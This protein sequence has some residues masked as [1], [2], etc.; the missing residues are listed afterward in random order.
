MKY[1]IFLL[2]F[3]SPLCK[4]QVDAYQKITSISDADYKASLLVPGTDTS[5]E[6]RSMLAPC[7]TAPNDNFANAITL[8]VNGGSVSGT[9][10]GSLES[11]ETTGCN[12]SAT[13][14][15]WY[16]FVATASTQ[17]VKIDLVSGS[18][19]FGS[20][21]YKTTTLPSTACSNNPISC[22]QDAAG[23]AT[24]IYQLSNCIIGS[25]YY[26]QI[27]YGGGGACGSSNTFNIGVT[28]ASPGGF[29][30]NPA[31][32]NTCATTNSG[33]YFNSPPTSA[34]VTS[35]CT[36]YSLAANGYG[37]NS[38]WTGFFQFTNSPSYNTAQI[39]AIISS[40]CFPLG[41]VNWLNWS[42]YSSGC[43]L[44]T[45]GTLSNLSIAGLACG[46]TY[47]LQYQV[48]LA[49]CSSFTSIWPYQNAPSSSPN[50]T[51]LPLE[52]L[53]FTVEPRGNVMDIK[54][55]T[56]NEINSKEFIIEKS[57]DAIN[58]ENVSVVKANQSPSEYSMKDAA[59]DLHNIVYYK[60]THVELNGK[61]TYSKVVSV[62]LSNNVELLKFSPNPAQDAFEIGF[63]EPYM[64]SNVIVEIYDLTGKKVLSQKILVDL[65]V[66]RI[67]IDH[68]PKGLYN[69]NVLSGDQKTSVTNLKL[70]KD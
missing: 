9:T 28:T 41:N 31:A 22:Q 55:Q 56:V 5:G 38:V 58:Y 62:V 16:K 3:I 67:E 43:G 30:S 13:S 15:V 14:S 6:H 68:L 18:C 57:Y 39:Q 61:T 65:K 10:C 42:I 7:T 49:N 48:E 4:A 25:T 34:Q 70:A 33:C 21:V 37:A 44:I 17:Y 69:V 1:F 63:S 60:L 40:N 36:G 45:C 12:T 32:L 27:I 20:A 47:I 19:Y 52:L 50:C 2:V 66:K 64:N 24:Q 53:Y 23:P 51:P 8:T 26:V 59:V 46:G 35:G 29:I 54:W 11:G